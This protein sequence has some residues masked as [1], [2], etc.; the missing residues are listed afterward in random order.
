MKV[1]ISADHRGLTLKNILVSWMKGDKI[2]V[3]DLGAHE[4]L[5]QDDY[6][7]YAKLVGEK[8]AEDSTTRGIVL[9]A[10]GVGINIAANKVNGI[11]S[12]L[13]FSVKQIQTARH[14]DDINVLALPAEYLSEEEAKEIV[15]VFLETQFA[16][17]EERFKRRIEKIK[18]IE[19]K[20]D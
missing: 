11:R 20:R 7:D 16:S 19:R 10:N 13:G 14:D 17:N 3:D 4:L 8:V 6:V 1:Y 12:A 9:C 5:P 18:E 2:D 15:T